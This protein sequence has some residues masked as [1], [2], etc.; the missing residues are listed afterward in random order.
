[1]TSQIVTTFQRG[2]DPLDY[3][4]FPLANAPL[5][6]VEATFR[7]AVW[8]RS[9]NLICCF[10]LDNGVLFSVGTFSHN[11][12]AAKRGGPSLRSAIPG[13]RF[14]LTFD[15]SPK[16]KW[17]SLVAC[18]TL[19][20]PVEKVDPNKS[21]NT[22]TI[23]VVRLL[24]EKKAKTGAQLKRL[25]TTLHKDHDQV[26]AAGRFGNNSQ[27]DLHEVLDYVRDWPDDW[28]GMRVESGVFYFVLSYGVNDDLEKVFWAA[29]GF[30]DTLFN[31]ERSY[32]YVFAV[33]THGN[34]SVVHLMVNR[35][36]ACEPTLTLRRDSDFSFE[37]LREVMA[38]TGREAGLVVT[39]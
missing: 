7:Q 2:K 11:H 28:A 32:D 12:Y 20:V 19:A 25:I 3:R 18:Q 17:P 6:E 5:G 9:A 1:M 14:R 37:R 16:S 15:Q 4:K 35:Y 27:P 31:D 26:F 29:N 22:D 39:L 21:T 33:K 23:A 24:K 38:S 30:A 34:R 10:E 36:S 13:T 8:G